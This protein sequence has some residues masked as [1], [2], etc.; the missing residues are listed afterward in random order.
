MR[1]LSLIILLG[2]PAFLLGGCAWEE[3]VR[4]A[5]VVKLQE[6]AGERIREGFS[7]IEMEE[8]R[9]VLRVEGSAVS[10]LLGEEKLAIENPRV[11]RFFPREDEKNSVKIEAQTGTW[12]R[13]SGQ[14][15]ME[16]GVEGVVRF[17]EEIFIE[18]ADKMIYDPL[19]HFLILTGE[20]RL[21]RGRSLLEADKVTIY[22]DEEEGR[23]VKITAEGRVR[24]RIFPEELER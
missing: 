3:E 15:E 13:E 23:V 1:S 5:T 11:E 24:A 18:H 20:V 10:G 14:V 12:D 22:L 4:E 19:A 8:G 21:R 6:E 7:H 9:I 16:V 2:L 17:E